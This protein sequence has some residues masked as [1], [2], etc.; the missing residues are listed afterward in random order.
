[1]ERRT[2]LF[3]CDS[4]RLPF[5]EGSF[6]AVFSFRAL[7]DIKS[8][9]GE[10]GVLVAVNE[11]CRVVKK[12]GVIALADDSFPCCRPKGDQGKLFS[13]IKR[14][15]GNLLPSTEDI[16]ETMRTSGISQVEVASYGPRESLLPKDAERELRLS[17]EWMKSFG[18]KVDFASFWNEAGGVIR[19]QG[20]IF[21]QVILLLGIKAPKHL[22]NR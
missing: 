6:D 13:A 12:G 8:T 3:A 9:R 22:K 16:I 5:K 18:V 7:Q 20:R 17:V 1:M 19:K 14:Y 4:T 15:W 21:P 11:A 10:E 2:A